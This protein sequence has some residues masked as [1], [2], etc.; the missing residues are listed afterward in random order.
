MRRLLPVLLL[1]LLTTA[2]APTREDVPDAESRG[3]DS[4]QSAF[5]VYEQWFGAEYTPGRVI[6]VD[7]D[8]DCQTILWNWGLDT[9]SL[10]SDVSWLQAWVYRGVQREWEGTFPSQ[11]D[12]QA[13]GGQ[14][15][16]QMAYFQG[17]FGSGDGGGGGDD[18]DVP[19]PVGDDPDGNS[20]RSQEGEF[21]FVAG[22]ELEIISWSEDRVR[23]YLGTE[24]GE[25]SFDAENCGVLDGDV[26]GFPEGDGEDLPTVP[27]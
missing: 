27:E 9:W 13:S 20:A 1:P 12:W 25:W 6:L 22:E 7:T 5:F 11:A 10:A 24:V 17:S 23:G 4:M 15:G 21:G 18:D 19:P 16:P 8:Y 2:C 3:G 14:W 26:V